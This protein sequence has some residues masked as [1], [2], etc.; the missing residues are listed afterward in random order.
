MTEP[1]GACADCGHYACVCTIRRRH[2]AACRFYIATTSPVGIECE[3]ELRRDAC[4]RCDA[5]SC[6]A[7]VV[8][9]DLGSEVLLQRWV[10]GTETSGSASAGAAGTARMA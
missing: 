10:N 1:G 8:A 5:C 2:T 7:D 4:P 9:A 3:C 6:G